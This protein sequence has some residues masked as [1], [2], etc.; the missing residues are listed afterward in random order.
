MLN[1]A[2]VFVGMGIALGALIY[3]I[4]RAYS[5]SIGP[6]GLSGRSY[7][8]RRTRFDWEDIDKVGRYAVDGAPSLLVTS[9]KSKQKIIIPTFGVSVPEIHRQ[10]VQHAGPDHILTKLFRPTAA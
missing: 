3:F 8:G 2:L 1:V 4:Y 10:L 7:W 6:A 9:A 5:W